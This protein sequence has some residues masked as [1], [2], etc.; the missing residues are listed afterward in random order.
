MDCRFHSYLGML[1]EA[2]FERLDSHYD[3]ELFRYWLGDESNLS[4]VYTD[5]YELVFQTELTVEQKNI[6]IKKGDNLEEKIRKWRSQWKAKHPELTN[7]YISLYCLKIKIQ[8]YL[9]YQLNKPEVTAF[10][11]EPCL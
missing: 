7:E 2:I 11:G 1:N 5:T 6:L 3:W 10:L 4:K 9:I 8:E